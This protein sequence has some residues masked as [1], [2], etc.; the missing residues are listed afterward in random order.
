MNKCACG[1]GGYVK[2]GNKFI[3]GHNK[4]TLGKNSKFKGKSYVEIYGE[5]KACE[6]LTKISES[7]LGE[8]NPARRP[9]VKRK[10]S[11]NRRGL[12]TG[13]NNPN[14]WLGRKNH[15][16]S[17]R[18]KSNNPAQR[19]DVREKSRN[20]ML[21]RW[22]TNGNVKIGT[23]EKKLLDDLEIILGKCIVRQYSVVGYAVDGYIPELNMVIE[24]D[25][26][27]HYDRNGDLRKKDVKRQ[28]LITESLNCDFIRV[29]DDTTH[30]DLKELMK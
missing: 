7:K 21:K 24:I 30:N 20:R 13:N 12:L 5:E 19:F 22:K 11:E 17:E 9:E 6:I 10:I 23:N 3:N 1:C 15:G 4:S 26:K 16:Q 18:M 2:T 8:K 29:R 28:Q 14:Y 25:E 27:H